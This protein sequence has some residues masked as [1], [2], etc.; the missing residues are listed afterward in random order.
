MNAAPS[1][2]SAIITWTTDVAG[3]SHVYYG[4]TTSYGS[5]VSQDTI[6]I[7][8]SHSVTITGL[9]ANTTYHFYVESV[10]LFGLSSDTSPDMV[11]TTLAVSI[12][13]VMVSSITVTTA[14]ITWT[15]ASSVAS[16][17]QYGTTTSYG[18]TVSGGTS[19]SHSATVTNLLSNATCHFRLGSSSYGYSDDYTFTTLSMVSNAVVSSITVSSATITWTTAS[20]VASEVQYGTTTSYGTTVSGGTGTSHSVTITGLLSNTIYHFRLGSSS[21]G[22]SGD[23]TLKTLS[24][25]SNVVVSSITVSSAT[26]TWTTASSVASEVQ[27]GTT[28]SYGTTVSGGT[29]TY[30]VTITGLLSNTVYHFRAGKSTSGC[31]LTTT[32]SPRLAWS[33]TSS[34][35]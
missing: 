5:H 30:S 22:Y 19:T 18:T 11:F 20:S 33:P 16:E 17:V 1:T 12:T 14:V 31:F 28:T 10:S 15:T 24:M 4:T 6:I 23:S 32:R 13:D 34:S 25:V 21:Y 2:T 35:A 26:I 27:Y 8:T 29:G 3:S 7:V 9:S